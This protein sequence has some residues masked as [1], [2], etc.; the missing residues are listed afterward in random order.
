MESI[1]GAEHLQQKHAQP[2]ADLR[3]GQG[4]RPAA[5]GG[6]LR[7]R[8]HSD[9]GQRH[10]VMPALPGPD[11]V[12][13]HACFILAALKAGFNA[14]SRFDDT[15]QFSQRR[16]LQCSVRHTRQ[17]QVVAIPIVGILIAVIQRG[18]RLHRTPV[19]EG[20]RVTTSHSSG[21]CV[22]VPDASARGV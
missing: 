1:P 14:W 3:Q 21:L 18:L 2:V 4:G 8:T 16:F 6:F 9:E 10:V 7:S 15:R 22:C 5:L 11:L 19:R 12:F 17:G 20:P 13:V